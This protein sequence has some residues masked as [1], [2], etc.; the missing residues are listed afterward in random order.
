MKSA[1][2]VI[3]LMVIVTY[4]IAKIPFTVQDEINEWTY[5]EADEWT[6]EDEKEW[7]EVNGR[8]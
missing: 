4:I 7:E 3:I 8:T 5:K 2:L 1:I 6:E